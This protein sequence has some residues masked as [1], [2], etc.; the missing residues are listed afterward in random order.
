[1]IILEVL[2]DGVGEGVKFHFV[3][4]VVLEEFLYMI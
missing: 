1:M 2:E 4:I 3:G